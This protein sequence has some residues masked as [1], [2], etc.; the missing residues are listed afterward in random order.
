MGDAYADAIAE[1]CTDRF[2][3]ISMAN[4]NVEFKSDVGR[5]EELRV[6]CLDIAKS[7][8][9]DFNCLSN[10]VLQLRLSHELLTA[11]MFATSNLQRACCRETCSVAR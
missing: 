8:G 5:K 2:A 9:C 10:S 6:Q 4:V 1:D 3:K 11:P 7:D